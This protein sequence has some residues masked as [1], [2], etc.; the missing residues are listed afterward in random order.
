MQVQ[1]CISVEQKCIL[2]LKKKSVEFFLQTLKYK[3]DVS[4]ML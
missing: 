2:K 4:F 1:V 3:V